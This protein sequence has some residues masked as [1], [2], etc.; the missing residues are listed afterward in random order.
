MRLLMQIFT[1]DQDGATTVEW[2]VITAA[3]VAIGT[4]LFG[5]IAY[6][7]DNAAQALKMQIVNAP[8]GISNH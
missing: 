7:T 8:G 5:S 1:E 2:V 4:I 3:V 6:G